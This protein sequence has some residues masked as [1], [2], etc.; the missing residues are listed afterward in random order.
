M[1]TRSPT[2]DFS[3]P[4][5]ANS[6]AFCEL[7][8]KVADF[9]PATNVASPKPPTCENTSKISLFLDNLEANS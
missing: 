5:C 7:S 3:A 8:T 1:V 6:N 9:A 2:P 4:F